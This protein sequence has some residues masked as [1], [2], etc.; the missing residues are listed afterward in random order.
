MIGSFDLVL[1]PYGDILGPYR[2]AVAG[3]AALLWLI[4]FVAMLSGI[5]VYAA[6]LCSARRRV[7]PNL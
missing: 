3:Y 7:A 2:S 1:E 5:A 6:R 4:A